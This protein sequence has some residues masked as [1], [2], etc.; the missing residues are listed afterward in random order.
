M[1]GF[2]GWWRSGGQARFERL[3]NRVQAMISH[4]SNPKRDLGGSTQLKSPWGE[5]SSIA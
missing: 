2:R 3:E 5:R 4:H 1:M